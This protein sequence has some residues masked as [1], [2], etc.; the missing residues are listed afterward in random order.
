MSLTHHKGLTGLALHQGMAVT[1]N[2]AGI[3]CLYSDVVTHRANAAPVPDFERYQQGEMA[4]PE[5]VTAVDLDFRSLE[6]RLEMLFIESLTRWDRIQAQSHASRSGLLITAPV[7][8]T[9]NQLGFLGLDGCKTVIQ[10]TDFANGLEQW[11]HTLQAYPDI[12]R[13]YWLALDSHCVMDW[14]LQQPQLY[15]ADTH[16][17]GVLAGEALVLTE[18]H[19]YGPTGPVLTFA[20]HAEEPNGANALHAPV[21]ARQALMTAAEPEVAQR[22]PQWAECLTNDDLTQAKG[23]ERY[24]TEVA[25]W[26]QYEAEPALGPSEP[27]ISWYAMT[28]DIGLATLPL[29]LLLARQRLDHPLHHRD[30]VGVMVNEQADRHYWRLQ[31]QGEP[32]PMAN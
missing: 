12:E 14:L 15:A 28:G 3:S 30:W 25:L 11:Q 18:W 29:G 19:R 10:A 23:A 8:I 17:E 5:V 26:P 21:S 6:A 2:P 7:S 32:Q 4:L 24:K 22:S 20:G 1:A 16:P 27:F 9:T 31:R 13:W